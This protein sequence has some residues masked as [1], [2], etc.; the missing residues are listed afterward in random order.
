M[1]PY[2]II[3]SI[4]TDRNE[5]HVDSSI[6]SKLLLSHTT[7][8]KKD[9]ENNLYRLRVILPTNNIIT[10]DRVDYNAFFEND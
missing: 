7:K 2:M 5:L 8:P 4:N 9:H 1:L 10:P 3:L 6:T